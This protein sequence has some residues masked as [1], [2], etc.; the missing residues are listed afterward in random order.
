MDVPA[1]LQGVALRWIGVDLHK[2]YAYVAELSADGTRHEYRVS[3]PSG[4]G[5]FCA[6][7]TS[8]DQVVVEASTSS[9]VLEKWW[10][11][12]PVE[13]WSLSRLRLEAPFRGRP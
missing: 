8:A 10:P 5:E 6:R 1:R 12:T 7:L 2:H 4:L 9:S 3:I 11:G 13:W